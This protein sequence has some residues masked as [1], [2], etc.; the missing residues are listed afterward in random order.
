MRNLLLYLFIATTAFTIKAQDEAAD[1]KLEVLDFTELK[2]TDA[3]NVTYHC[4]ADSA[5]WAYFSCEPDVAQRLLFTNNKSQLHIQVDNSDGFNHP[6]P[7]V[8]V[9]SSS[10]AK[11]DNSADS[12]VI[13]ASNTAVQS[14][15]ARIVGNGSLIARNI[16]AGQIDAGINT[17]KGHLVISGTATKVKLS[18]VG[19]GTIEA[20][21]LK[22]R[23]VKV[24]ML[25][26]GD[27]DCY[28][29]ESLSIYGTG[30]GKIYYSGHPEKIINRSLGVKA[31]AMDD[32]AVNE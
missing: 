27:I 8:H 30:S 28:A 25:G 29:T 15:K 24:M 5:G 31:F 6:L 20:G 4:S 11:V 10:L 23:V 13:V 14:F 2:V 19:T 16:Q 17:G 21:S 22:G 1:Y 7:M 18:N 26:T 9:Y 32:P 3:V 12:T